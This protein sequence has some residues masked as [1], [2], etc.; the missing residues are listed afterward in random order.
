MKHHS[1]YEIFPICNHYFYNSI[2]TNRFP[3]ICIVIPMLQNFKNIPKI[4][5]NLQQFAT[6]FQQFET[7]FQLFSKIFQKFGTG[8]QQSPTAFQQLKK[9]IEKKV[10]QHFSH[11]NIFDFPPFFWNIIQDTEWF[12]R[13]LSNLQQNWTLSNNLQYC[14][15]IQRHFSN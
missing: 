14:I 3:T 8:F 4:G 11:L 9:H 10:Q 7:T 2:L 6:A 13:N 5:N 12:R 1:R 15:R